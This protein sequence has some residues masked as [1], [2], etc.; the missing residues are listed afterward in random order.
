[1]LLPILC[2]VLPLCYYSTRYLYLVTT[3]AITGLAELRRARPGDEAVADVDASGGEIWLLLSLLLL[4]LLLLM[5][6][7]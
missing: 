4:L 6:I 2:Y 7:E 1:M 5:T 3:L